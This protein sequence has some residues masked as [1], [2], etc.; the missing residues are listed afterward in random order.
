M[1]FRK[2]DTLCEAKKNDVKTDFLKIKN[3]QIAIYQLGL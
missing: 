2:Y 1:L 3:L